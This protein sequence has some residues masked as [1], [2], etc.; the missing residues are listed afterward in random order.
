MIFLLPKP[1][2][3]AAST[4]EKQRDL[5]LLITLSIQLW[6]AQL[7]QHAQ[8]EY[9]DKKDPGFLPSR[10]GNRACGQSIQRPDLPISFQLP[11][12]PGDS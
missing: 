11:A 12:R 6:L 4:H 9:A 7:L 1:A 8:A 2:E 5:E 3:D 10:S